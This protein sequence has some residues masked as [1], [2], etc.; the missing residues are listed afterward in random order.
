LRR[1]VFVVN[2]QSKVVYVDYM[3]ALGVEPNYEDVL[4]AAKG[5]I[6]S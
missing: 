1:A 4:N 3:T 5:A 2:K 6:K